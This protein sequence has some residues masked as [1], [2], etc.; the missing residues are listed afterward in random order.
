[1]RTRGRT[2]SGTSI[3]LVKLPLKL[4]A[5]SSS[6]WKK[7]KSKLKPKNEAVHGSHF[8]GFDKYTIFGT[9]GGCFVHL[10]E[11]STMYRK[12][13]RPTLDTPKSYRSRKRELVVEGGPTED[14]DCPSSLFTP[15]WSFFGAQS[16]HYYAKAWLKRARPIVD[17][18]HWIPITNVNTC[19]N[20]FYILSLG[21]LNSQIQCHN[22]HSIRL[23][24]EST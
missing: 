9:P 23:V 19:E 10:C 3:L 15:C 18:R 1:M 14:R 6:P 5:T 11:P 16:N 21:F 7:E 8:F 4:T 20:E 17:R 13:P 22:Y 2:F 12:I 24:Q